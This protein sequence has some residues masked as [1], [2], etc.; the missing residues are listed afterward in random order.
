MTRVD[1]LEKQPPTVPL[2]EKITPPL[3]QI[4]KVFFNQFIAGLHQYKIMVINTVH[5]KIF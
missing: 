3:S 2:M 1:A 5:L 4:T